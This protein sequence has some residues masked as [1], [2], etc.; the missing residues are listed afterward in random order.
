[1]WREDTDVS[2]TFWKQRTQDLMAHIT[3]IPYFSPH[4]TLNVKGRTLYS[5]VCYNERC[6]N[7]RML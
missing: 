3:Y 2:L 6:Y 5:G 1:M 4:K 7:E